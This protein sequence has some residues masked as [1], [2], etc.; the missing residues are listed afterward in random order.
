MIACHHGDNGG[1]LQV[2]TIRATLLVQD[3]YFNITADT[4]EAIVLGDP[5][6]VHPRVDL[7][8]GDAPKLLRPEVID[9]EYGVADARALVDASA[10]GRDVFR[11]D[12]D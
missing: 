9:A 5:Y 8:A 4:I 10:A 6:R 2:G 7:R 3:T 11:D 12:L 1:Y